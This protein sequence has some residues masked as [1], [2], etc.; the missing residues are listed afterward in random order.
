VF[1][2]LHSQQYLRPAPAIR[3]R[4]LDDRS[5][6]RI[7]SLDGKLE[8]KEPALSGAYLAGHGLSFRLG[9]DYDSTAVVLDKVN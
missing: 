9:G 4:G 1:A 5:V 3:L 6:Y 2:F 8:Q 7:R